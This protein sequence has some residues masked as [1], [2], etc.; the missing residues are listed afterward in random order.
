MQPT[1]LTAARL[2]PVPRPTDDLA[3]CRRILARGS[4][5]FA[6][7]SLLLPRRVRDPAAAV[8]AFCR[9]A[10][11]AVDLG[12]D[13]RRAVDALH[14][15]LDRV[16]AGRPL[17]GPVDRAFTDVVA[18]FAIPRAVPEALL[19]GFAWD[20]EGRR[21]RDLSS[22]LD[23]SARVASTVGVM[24]TLL[25]GVRD[26]RVL[27]RAADLG[28]AMQLTNIARDVG[29]D[30]RAGRLYLPEAWFLDVDLDPER[31]LAEPAPTDAVR[32]LVARLLDEADVLYARA[33]EG[34]AGLPASCRPAIRGARLVYSAIGDVIRARRYDTI[35]GRAHTGAGRKIGLLARALASVAWK[36][37]PLGDVVLPQV[38]FL[39]EAVQ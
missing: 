2:A 6:A 23:Y 14:D 15:R 18:S 11:D 20:A 30:A 26:R 4:K 35:T 21:V 19:E 25:M 33:D 36:P 7:A 8:Y 17:D 1:S 5:S 12:E 10:D 34:I 3:E 38:R 32:A 13:P 29:E 24:M 27:A 28:A 16:Y 39:V 9:V 31:F 22:V 37:K